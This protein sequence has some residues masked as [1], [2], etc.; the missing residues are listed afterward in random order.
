MI[1][2]I[3]SFSDNDYNVLVKI[4]ERW[5]YENDVDVINISFTSPEKCKFLAFVTYR[6]RDP[7]EYDH[8]I[9]L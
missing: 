4:I 3:K 6:I 2:K 1:V 5:I 7:W 8:D 9:S